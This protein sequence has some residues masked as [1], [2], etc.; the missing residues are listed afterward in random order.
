MFT[1]AGLGRSSGP[2]GGVTP[3]GSGY[4]VVRSR[5]RITRDGGHSLLAVSK[6]D[7]SSAV[8]S[9]PD[10]SK[11]N[12]HEERSSAP[13]PPASDSRPTGLQTPSST[14]SCG[15]AHVSEPFVEPEDD[16]TR[17]IGYVVAYLRDEAAAGHSEV[18]FKKT[19]N[20]MVANYDELKGSGASGRMTDLFLKAERACRVNVRYSG[21]SKLLSLS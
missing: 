5:L 6:P 2:D 12:L 9:L 19:R 11:L 1:A 20:F 4:M 17:L 15:S 16:D 13:S 21:E 14:G 3:F 10:M 7:E 18:T 8:A